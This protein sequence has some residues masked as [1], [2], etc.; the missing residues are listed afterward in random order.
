MLTTTAWVQ[1]VGPFGADCNPAIARLI[2]S[3]TSGTWLNDRLVLLAKRG[4]KTVPAERPGNGE[5]MDVRSIASSI[6]A[7]GPLGTIAAGPLTL[8]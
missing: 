4:N 3:H 2:R 8:G 7:A 6:V 5:D 1:C